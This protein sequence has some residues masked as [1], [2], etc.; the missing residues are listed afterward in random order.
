MTDIDETLRQAEAWLHDIDGVEGVAQGEADGAVCITVFVTLDEAAEK[1]PA[2]FHGYKVVVE[3][4][5]EF[6]AQL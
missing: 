5:D 3:H 6:T 1:I 4:T 2:T